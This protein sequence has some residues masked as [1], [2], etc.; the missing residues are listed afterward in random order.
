MQNDFTTA[1]RSLKVVGVNYRHLHRAGAV[2]D[3]FANTVIKHGS[4]KFNKY[5]INDD[6]S[7]ENLG[8]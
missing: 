2:V 7:R 1:V 8:T 4:I 5:I 6:Y 3:A